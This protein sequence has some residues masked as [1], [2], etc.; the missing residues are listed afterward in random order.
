MK[1]QVLILTILIASVNLFSQSYKPEK[2]DIDTMDSFSP[3]TISN[4][5]FAV[6]EELKY[7]VHYGW[8][9]AG[10]AVLKVEKSPYSFQGKEA[11]HIVGTGRSLGGFNWVFKVNDRY[12]SYVDKEGLYPYRFIRDVNEG[13]YKIKQDY[14]FT[15][16]K[17]VVDFGNQENYKTPEHVQDMMSAFYYARTLDFSNVQPGDIYTIKTVIDEEIFHLKIKYVQ[18]EIIDIRAGEFRC[19]KFV[20]ILQE[21][22]IFEDEEDLNVW[23]TDDANKIPILVKSKLLIGSIKMEMTEWSGLSNPLAKLD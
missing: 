9:D 2:V 14:K 19:M 17:T 10:E 18:T 3:R 1:N 23:I 5:A 6:G 15:P 13:G 22:R 7:K 4:T 16:K 12:E 20:P 21:G 11:L 8:V